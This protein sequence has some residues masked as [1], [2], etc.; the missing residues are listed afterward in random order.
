MFTAAPIF[1]GFPSPFP[2]QG[3]SCHAPDKAFCRPSLPCA[4]C[5]CSIER[6]WLEG[7]VDRE[8]G[9][10]MVF[11]LCSG[12]MAASSLPSCPP[13]AVGAVHFHSSAWPLL[14]GSPLGNIIPL[15]SLS[16]QAW[17]HVLLL[18]LMLC[19]SLSFHQP[20][21]SVAF[22]RQSLVSVCCCTADQRF[23]DSSKNKTCL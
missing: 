1:T 7:G 12:Q 10:D 19:Y 17:T 18:C 3:P 14:L 22:K 15:K 4:P 5:F 8:G 6:G 9:V 21:L 2:L 23:K 16:L 20:G 11:E 13:Q